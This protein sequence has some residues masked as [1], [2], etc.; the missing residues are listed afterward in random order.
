MSVFMKYLVIS[1]AVICTACTP[2]AGSP[3]ASIREIAQRPI[4]V[5]KFPQS[6]NTYLSFSQSHG[7][8]VNY[9]APSGEA[10]LWYPGNWHAIAEKWR[11]AHTGG[12]I[13]WRHLENS[14][15]PVT[16]IKGGIEQCESVF[17]AKRSIIASLNGD[18]FKLSSGAVPYTL[19][20]CQAP[21]AF[22]FSRDTF[23][24]R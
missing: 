21:T 5:E 6:G 12:A 7:F 19:P 15:N 14:F 17:L 24:C 2:P 1:V 3:S 10:W 22:Q 20:K 4:Q 23:R 11:V 16:G 8:Q 18:P 13:C 9:L